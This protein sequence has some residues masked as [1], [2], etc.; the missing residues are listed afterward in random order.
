MIKKVLFVAYN[1]PP[2][3][4]AGVQ[5]SLKF[6]KYLPTVGWEPIV[7]TTTP[8][9]YPVRDESLKAD[10]PPETPIYRAKSYDINSLRPAFKRLGLENLLT[11]LN[12]ALQL[13]DAALFWTRLA[14][15]LLSRAIEAHRP[16]VLYSSH[17]PASAHLLGMWAQHTFALPW[18]AD[19]RD[20][21]SGSQLMPY[22]PGYRAINR[23]ME[24]RVLRNADH[25]VTVSEPLAEDLQSLSQLE[26]LPISV[27]ENGYDAEDVVPFP[28][29]NS[30]PFTITYTGTFSRLRRPD[31]FLTAMD[32]LLNQERISADEVRVVIAGKN[33]ERYVPTRPPFELRGYLDHRD[34]VKLRQETDLFLL[35]QNEVVENRRAYSGKL[36]EYLAA[37]R[38]TLAIVPQDGVAAE[39][40]R[41]ARAGSVVPHH[42]ERIADVVL[43]YY[44]D[45]KSGQADYTPDWKI[46]HR[47]SR[48]NLT[49]RL[50]EL[51]EELTGE[52]S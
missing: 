23:R 44:H 37:N 31:A 10:I 43:R 35:V 32:Q 26:N 20:P 33:T 22:Y 39:L 11:A 24:R 13:P 29:H 19:F 48:R 45:W 3:G 28:P 17:G 36:Y 42:P 50:A 25:V 40:V 14:R 30:P 38:P 46:I 21:W 41:R 1:F 12:V 6:V 34:L 4:G 51:F 5:R 49:G 8:D 16:D 9:A 27:I 2:A 52:T 7:I 15:P 18:V 47:Y